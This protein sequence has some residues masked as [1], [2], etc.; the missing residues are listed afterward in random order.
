MQEQ[1]EGVYKII[2]PILDKAPQGAI[3]IGYSQG[4]YQQCAW[5]G[6]QQ[7]LLSIDSKLQD[8]CM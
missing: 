1:S 2:A 6:Y 7:Y 3:F 8:G 5:G 4:I